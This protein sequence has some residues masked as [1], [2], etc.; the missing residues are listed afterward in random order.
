VSTES[1][2]LHAGSVWFYRQFNFPNT[3]ET[4]DKF[5][6]VLNPQAANGNAYFVLP[7]SQVQ[8]LLGCKLLVDDC[9]VVPQGV[10]AFFTVETAIRVSNIHFRGAAEIRH[11]YINLPFSR[12]MEYKG[13]L[14]QSI[15]DEI[16]VLIKASKR[17]S[18]K[19]KGLVFP[20]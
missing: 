16:R 15:F 6:V 13:Q 14:P 5:I 7:T 20:E 1:G 2:P 12:R 10:V 17:I 8:K 11:A 9:V 18:P 4:R 3:W 19:L